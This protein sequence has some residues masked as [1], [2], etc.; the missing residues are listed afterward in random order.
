[1]TC[2]PSG[3]GLAFRE[4]F[5]QVMWLVVKKLREEKDSE[6]SQMLSLLQLVGLGYNLSNCEDFKQGDAKAVVLRAHHDQGG[7]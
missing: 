7:L 5:Q 2:K 6:R 3:M 1:M 4:S